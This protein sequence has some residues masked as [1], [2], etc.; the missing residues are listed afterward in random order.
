MDSFSSFFL[1]MNVSAN[2][3][4]CVV[5]HDQYHFLCRWRLKRQMWQMLMLWSHFI[6]VRALLSYGGGGT[7]AVHPS[8]PPNIIWANFRAY[9]LSVGIKVQTNNIFYTFLINVEL[10]VKL[11][12]PLEVSEIQKVEE[13]ETGFPHSKLIPQKWPRKLSQVTFGSFF[14]FFVKSKH[15]AHLSHMLD[16]PL[17]PPWRKTFLPKVGQIYCR[18]IYPQSCKLHSWSFFIFIFHFISA[19][20]LSCTIWS[21]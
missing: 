12:L 5:S 14:L 6:A 2:F 21:E 18:L 8:P 1:A 13:V 20:S 10:N 7:L 9:K 3:Q 17:F 11:L 19:F 4:K 16:S 15:V